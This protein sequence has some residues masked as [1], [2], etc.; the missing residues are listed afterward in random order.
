MSRRYLASRLFSDS[1]GKRKHDDSSLVEAE[2]VSLE[3]NFVN[4]V[5]FSVSGKNSQVKF[6]FF[7][8]KEERVRDDYRAS[9]VLSVRTTLGI[10]VIRDRQK[11]ESDRRLLGYR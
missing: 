1:A 5:S 6:F 3:E 2:L 8:V 11:E 7:L 4:S 10:S 9:S